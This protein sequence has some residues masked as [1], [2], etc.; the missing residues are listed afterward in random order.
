MPTG[1][2]TVRTTH[3]DGDTAALVVHGVLS[4]ATAPMLRCVVDDHRRA[5]RRF[6]RVNCTLLRVAP[7]GLGT[8]LQLHQLLLNVHG[9]LILTNVSD[10]LRTEL[11]RGGVADVLFLIAPTAADVPGR[12]GV[13]TQLS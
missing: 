8:L 9:T 3:A 5:G 12:P 4:A 2:L 11:R 6:L 1:P 13:V 7:D 10:V